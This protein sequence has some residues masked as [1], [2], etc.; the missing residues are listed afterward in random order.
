MPQCCPKGTDSLLAQPHPL[1]KRTP[2][3]SVAAEPHSLTISTPALRAPIFPVLCTT[4]SILDTPNHIGDEMPGSP[5]HRATK[6][7]RA[8]RCAV[9][10]GMG[11]I[12]IGLE[13]S[14]LGVF[15]V[16]I[17]LRAALLRLGGEQRDVKSQQLLRG[18]IEGKA[19]KKVAGGRWLGT[20]L[21][22]LPLFQGSPAGSCPQEEELSLQG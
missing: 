22:R 8:P 19:V 7:T 17:G 13:G 14:P 21:P 16:E 10:M 9:P 3:T 15:F 18:A 12:C 4:Q 6:H 1:S 20:P 11:S 2:N 5:R